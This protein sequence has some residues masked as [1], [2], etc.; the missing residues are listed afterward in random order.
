MVPFIILALVGGLLIFFGILNCRGNLKPLHSYH[1]KRVKK[2]DY[3]KFGR[4]VG[5]GNILIGAAVAL[6]GAS[7]YVYEKTQ[8]DLWV[9]VGLLVLFAG[10]G[11]GMAI[12]FAAMQKYNKG[13][14]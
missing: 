11:V 10:L 13:I 7:F 9:T 4:R 5:L 2:A 3:L 12:T 14:F 1:Y 8:S 6:Y